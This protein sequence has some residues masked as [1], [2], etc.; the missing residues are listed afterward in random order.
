MGYPSLDYKQ[1]LLELNLLPLTLWFELQNVLLFRHLV[2]FPPDNYNL[3]DFVHFSDSST[4]SATAGK[5]IPSSLKIPRL[6][7]TKHFYYNRIIM[8]WNSLPPFDL[9]LSYVTLKTK[10]KNFIWDY[11]L[12]NYCHENPHSWYC[13]CPCSSCSVVTLNTILT[14]LSIYNN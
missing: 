10:F 5:L 6:D 11:F 12:N 14:H 2:K 7:R 3:S 9:H 1:R 8:I 4:C 13:V